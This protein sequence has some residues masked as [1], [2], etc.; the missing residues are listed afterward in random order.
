MSEGKREERQDIAEF[1]EF[2]PR[3]IDTFDLDILADILKDENLIAK[4]EHLVKYLRKKKV[5]L[6]D[7]MPSQKYLDREYFIIEETE[8]NTIYGNTKFSVPLITPAGQRWLWKKLEKM[9]VGKK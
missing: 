2:D 3:V 7:G 1:I 8:C 5:L 6:E 9:K 4:R